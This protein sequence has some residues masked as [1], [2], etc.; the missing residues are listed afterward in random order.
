MMFRRLYYLLAGTLRRQL[1][2][3][4]AVI[5]SITMS[6]FIWDQT[7]RQQSVLLEQ[8]TDQ[9]MVLAHSVATSAAVR[10]SGSNR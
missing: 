2:V 5:L 7:R 9:A 6:A 8:Q 10:P 4:M 3:G 1:I